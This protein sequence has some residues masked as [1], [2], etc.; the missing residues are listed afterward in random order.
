ME[1][2]ATCDNWEFEV[3]Y[4]ISISHEHLKKLMVFM[5]QQNKSLINLLES[6]IEHK[7]AI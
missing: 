6:I 3:E 4:L 2:V 7:I 5:G 1:L